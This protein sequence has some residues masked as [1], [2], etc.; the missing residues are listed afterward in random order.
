MIALPV[1][2]V[3]AADVV[4]QTSD[5]TG[6]ESLDR[7]LGLGRRARRRRARARPASSRC[8]TPTTAPGRQPRRSD[9]DAVTLDDVREALGR[10]VPATS[11]VRDGG[12]RVD[13]ERGVVDVEATELD[14]ADPLVDGLF[15]AD[16]RAAGR[17]ARRG[18]RQ[19]ARSPSKGFAVGYELDRPTTGATLT[20]VGIGR[21]D[22]VPRL[23]R[24][25]RARSGRFGL[26]DRRAGDL[27][28]RAAGRSR[29]T[30]VRAL[31]QVGA[32]VA[33]ARGASS[34][35]PPDSELPPELS[36]AGTGR[37]RV[38]RRRRADRGDGAARGGAARRPGLRGRRPPPAAHPG[39]DGRQRRYADAGAPRRSSR[40]PRARRASRAVLGVV[41][42]RRSSAGPLL[43]G[44]PALLRH[45][46][47]PVRRALAAP[48]RR[49]PAFGLLSAFLAAR[50]ARL[51][52]PRGRTSWPCSPAAA[53]TARP[54]PALAAARP[55]AARRR[56][57]RRPASAPRAGGG[58]YLDRRLARSSRCSA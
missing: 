40:R 15:R 21:V 31:N 12:S 34:D 36:W 11:S 16:R 39:P 35:P 23:T 27:A 45:L 25:R 18:G 57:R 26:D 10:D 6:V 29:G 33:V 20:V 54:S 41:P 2:A 32:T 47:R 5:V 8:P 4:F 1:L 13:T 46:A 49:S 30:T 37:R 56:H 44:R 22:D 24:R 42:G 7:R 28:R 58:E 3:T 55:G 48:A 53:A 17:G 52:S 14:L 43:P 19:R 38:A 51:A 9:G 50:G